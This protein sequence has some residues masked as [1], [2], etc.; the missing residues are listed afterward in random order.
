[1]VNNVE[2]GFEEKVK[3]AE[4]LYDFIVQGAVIDTGK[5][6]EQETIEYDCVIIGSGAGGSVA[7]ANLA[8]AG[9]SVLIVEK[10]SYVQQHDISQREAEALDT[11]YERHGLLTTS[12]GQVMILAGSTLG[13]GTTINW[14]CCIE[15][16]EHVRAEWVHEHGLTQF[17]PGGEFDSSMEHVL[18]RIGAKRDHIALNG[19]NLKLEKG[20]KAMNAKYEY[21]KQNLRDCEAASAGYICFGDRTGNKNGALS[22]F[23]VDAAKNE[24]KIITN[25]RANHVLFDAA[26]NSKASRKAVG[27]SLSV[28]DSVFNVKA[29]RCVISA[30]G[31]LHSPCFLLRSGL[32]NSH[33][34]KHLHLHPVVGA[35]G[36]FSDSIHGY[37]QAPMTIACKDVSMGPKLDGYGAFIECPSTHPGLA[38]ATLPWINAEK[39]RQNI[40]KLKNLS[41]NIVLQ[42]DKSEGRIRLSDDGFNP[43]IDYDLIADDKTSMSEGLIVATKA[44]IA[45]G[46]EQVCT[47]SNTDSGISFTDEMDKETPLVN[48]LES[49]KAKAYLALMKKKGIEKHSIGVFSAHQMGTC[50]LSVSPNRGVCDENGETWDCDD[51]YIC[52]ASTFPTA[53]GANPMCTTLAISHMVSSRIVKR[54]QYEDNSLTGDLLLKTRRLIEEHKVKRNERK[55]HL[56]RENSNYKLWNVISVVVLVFAALYFQRIISAASERLDSSLPKLF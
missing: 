49:K 1:L 40:S 44:L 50:R 41:A 28:G 33:I 13:G 12:D 36:E 46:A 14:S 26:D 56:H 53:S 6:K 35:L 16:P 27:V 51:L 4:E 39:F 31:S 47:A 25:A 37:L 7:A 18:R 23:L 54:L 24:A 52:D 43:I 48:R 20:L 21:T 3:G 29:K 2:G 17:E 55:L 5:W 45:S 22:T 30:A 15:T 10:G 11:M 8:E 19:M 38:A 42:R 34:G 9:Y 32:A